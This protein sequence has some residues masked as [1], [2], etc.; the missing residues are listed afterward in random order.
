MQTVTLGQRQHLLPRL[1]L[2]QEAEFRRF[3]AQNDVVQHGEALH[4]LEVLVYHADAQRGGVIG[5][6]DGHRFAILPDF[7]FLR[8][9]QAEKDAHQ[10]RFARAV[11]TQQRVDFAVAQLEGDVVIGNDAGKALGDMQH[12]DGIRRAFV[13]RL[14]A[15][16][17]HE[18]FPP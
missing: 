14:N 3:N 17:L 12:F 13:R 7:A 6:A 18:A 15:L 4:Q 9:I 1:F 5:V 10:R 8:L 11:L 16:F 2:L